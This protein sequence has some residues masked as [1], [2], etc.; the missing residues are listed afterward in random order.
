MLEALTLKGLHNLPLTQLALK[1]S[2][3]CCAIRALL[4]CDGLQLLSVQSS[5]GAALLALDDAYRLFHCITVLHHVCSAPIC[6]A[7]IPTGNCP[8]AH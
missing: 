1:L 7:K 5:C 8:Y 2:V 6:S 4:M 3:V